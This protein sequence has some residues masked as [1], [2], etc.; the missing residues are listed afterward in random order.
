MHALVLTLEFSTVNYK[1]V[2][3]FFHRLCQMNCC[4]DLASDGRST[5]KNSRCFSCRNG[6]IDVNVN[7]NSQARRHTR[8]FCERSS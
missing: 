8:F 2:K 4:V 5:N 3:K 7:V 6:K 1:V